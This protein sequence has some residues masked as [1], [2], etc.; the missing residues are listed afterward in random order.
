MAITYIDFYAEN[1]I[2]D[3]TLDNTNIYDAITGNSTNILDITNA[4]QDVRI[5][6]T[7]SIIF[8][9]NNDI[10]LT[11]QTDYNQV[12]VG[13]QNITTVGTMYFN[14]FGAIP[15]PSFTP[16]HIYFGQFASTPTTV[17]FID[18]STIKIPGGNSGDVL[19]TD[20]S[21]NLSFIPLSGGGVT[22][23]D[24]GDITVSG[25]GSVWTIDNSVVTY[26]KM[27][28]AS[29]HSILGR[30]SNTSGAIGEITSS[31]NGQVLHRN[32]SN[33]V[34]GTIGDSSIT[35]SSISYSRLQDVSTNNRL[36]GRSTAGA[37]SI[38]E[39]IVGS[40][41]TLS[42]GTL[43]ASGGGSGMQ[44]QV[45]TIT[46][47]QTWL[48]PSWGKYYKVYL[49]G[50]GSGGG[51]GSRQ[52]TTLARYGG[53]GGAGSNMIV[54]EYLDSVVPSSLLVSI[55]AGGTGGAS[56][57]SDSTNGNPGSVGGVSSFGG[58]LSTYVSSNGGGSGGTTSSGTRGQ[59]YTL[60]TPFSY[61]NIY[62]SGTAGRNGA[63]DQRITTSEFT[64]TVAG[65]TGGGGGAGA[66]AN[67]TTTA[68]G[69][70]CDLWSSWL[71][72]APSTGGSNGG[73]GN[74]GVSYNYSYF[75]AGTPGGGGSYKTGQST[76]AGGNGS[77]GSG[78]GGGAASDNG[79]NSGA[80]GNGGN[81]ICII[82]TIG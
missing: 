73:N 42:A 20:G 77:Y 52:A 50:G 6:N 26:G 63:G 64:L 48:K 69:G 75:T 45:D 55:G 61:G 57:T 78:G 74:N 44:V 7:E 5:T 27:Q 60:V 4:G 38:E 33:L 18:N 59:G 65:A 14:Y 66:S 1:P 10:S 40:G 47:S 58:L 82:I 35:S 67:N 19:S 46:T 25:S 41:L 23:G 80:G 9:A 39:I 43:S 22:D 76:G 28:D 51:S 71:L 32:G 21:G 12:V 30:S 79:F 70:T 81:G 31:A 11:T 15:S 49:Y 2:H 17:H 72:V 53:G 29:G 68:S 3:K 37:G 56:V 24:Y 13:N 16:K 54:A 36:L 8:N 62:A 34:F